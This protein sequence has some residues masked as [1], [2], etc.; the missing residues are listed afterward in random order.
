VVVVSPPPVNCDPYTDATQ[1]LRIQPAINAA[2]NNA[3]ISIKPGQYMEDVIMYKPVQLQGWGAASTIIDNTL[4]TGN[5]PGIDAWNTLFQS[6]VGATC[7]AATPCIS[8]PPGG[9]ND[10]TFEQGAGI[11]VAACDPSTNTCNNAFTTV[12]RGL[13]DGLTIT[14]ATEAGGG[15]YVNSYA[16]YLKISNNQIYAN[17]GNLSGGIR[18][19][20]PSLVN[21]SV[22]TNSHNENMV[23]SNNYVAQNGSF[24]SG[25]GGVSLYKGADSYKVT[26][27]MLCGNFSNLYG[28]GICHFGLSPNGLIQDNVLVSN[29]SFDEGGGIMVAGELPIAGA[30]AP[31]GTLTEGAGSVVIDSNLIQ[32]NKGGDDGGG[33]RTLMFNGQDFANNKTTPARWFTI[34]ITNNMVVNNMSGDHGGGLSFDDTVYAY[35]INN[36]IAHNDSTA[37]GSGAFTN[38]ACVEGDP[39]GQVCPP[40]GEA[41]G[42]LQ[43][44]TPRVGGIASYYYSTALASTLATITNASLPASLKTYCNPY[45]YNDIIWQNQSYYWD[46]AANSNMGGL[47]FS[48]IWDLA[49]YGG[50]PTA[51][52]TN[53]HN[54]LMTASLGNVPAASNFFGI[55]PLFVKTY[56]NV[57]EASSKGAAFGNFVNVYFN[58]IGLMNSAYALYGD[59]HITAS[60]PARDKGTLAI[61]L[62]SAAVTPPTLFTNLGLDYDTQARP[63]GGVD[64]GADEYYPTTK[65]FP[66]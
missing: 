45:L 42:G 32:G 14:G 24:S 66:W 46:A 29:E 38:G 27:N 35:V 60:S 21:G 25:G 30:P 28:G 19:G 34:S 65:W 39:T 4:A 11:M 37:T 51:V 41:I 16:P 3:I 53:T 49:I 13:I 7:S 40:P 12:R 50:S 62:P 56:F 10:F 17:Q 18:I 64:I 36:T 33:I 54:S 8:I 57:Y 23:I 47:I 58:P 52:F 59:Y 9:T 63:N 22:Y 48:S 61:T 1:C 44:S 5:F 2:P 55:D 20:T 15:I 43:N 26:N 31:A 6:L